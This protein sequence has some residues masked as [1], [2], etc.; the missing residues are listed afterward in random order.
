MDDNCD[1]FSHTFTC[2]MNPETALVVILVFAVIYIYI[3]TYSAS[4]QYI[5]IENG[6]MI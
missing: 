2:S 5:C 3:Y 1:Y 4:C 6:S